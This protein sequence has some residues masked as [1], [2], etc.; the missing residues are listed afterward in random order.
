MIQKPIVC[1][2][3]LQA[4]MNRQHEDRRARCSQTVRRQG[5]HNSIADNV[6]GEALPLPI[7]VSLANDV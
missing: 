3:L 5:Q 6:R 2:V 7:A 1:T 4:K